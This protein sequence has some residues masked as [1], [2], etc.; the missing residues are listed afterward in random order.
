MQ[1]QLRHGRLQQ[2]EEQG[3]GQRHHRAACQLVHD[4][5]RALPA[6]GLCRESAGAHAQ[7][8][9]HPVDDVEE[10]AAHSDGPQIDFGAEMSRDGNVHQPQ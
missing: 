3:E 8:A 4:V 7:E 9:E 1:G 5:V 10:H 2:H 6:V